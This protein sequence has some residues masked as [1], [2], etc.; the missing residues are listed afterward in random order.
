MG[1]IFKTLKLLILFPIVLLKALL[2]GIGL[3]IVKLALKKRIR[4]IWMRLMG[5]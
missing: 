1:F 4:K 2:V 5:L 3:F